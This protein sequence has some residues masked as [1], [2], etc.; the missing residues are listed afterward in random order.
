MMEIQLFVSTIGGVW[1]EVCLA[2]GVDDQPMSLSRLPLDL[3]ERM[4]TTTVLLH[5]A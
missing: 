4:P 2:A 5:G 1:F 3:A